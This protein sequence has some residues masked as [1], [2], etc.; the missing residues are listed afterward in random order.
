[1]RWIELAGLFNKMLDNIHRLVEGMKNFLD[2][3]AHDLRTPITRFR[4]IAEMALQDDGDI[5]I[6]KE[7]LVKSIE[8]SDHILKM[9][10]TLMDISEAETG[11]M[12]MHCKQVD[13]CNLI[14]KIADMYAFVA[15]E[16]GINIDINLS[17]NL[18]ISIDSNRMGQAISNILDNA[19]KFTDKRRA[20]PY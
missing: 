14:R 20:H 12:N 18:Y 15:E 8:E 11:T 13:I 17:E 16:K 4:N 2:N 7:A 9:L 10:N 3:V 19:I 1:M 6:L 5:D